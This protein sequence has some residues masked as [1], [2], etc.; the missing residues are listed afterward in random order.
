APVARI[1]ARR[2]AGPWDWA[3]ANRARVAA[4][5]ADLTHANPSLYNGRVLVRRRQDLRDGL[6][7]LSYVETGYASF[8]AFRD[9]GFPDPTTGN[10]FALAALRAADGTWLLG[11]MGAHTANAGRIY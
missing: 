5:W 6:L 7:R 10:G 8:I 11:R 9:F 4:H 3:D 1:E 2:V